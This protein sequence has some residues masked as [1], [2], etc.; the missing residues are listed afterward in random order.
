MTKQQKEAL[1]KLAVAPATRNAKGSPLGVAKFADGTTLNGNLLNALMD[2]G[3]VFGKGSGEYHTR[4]SRISKRSYQVEMNVYAI[5]EAG[6]Q[7]LGEQEPVAEQAPASPWKTFAAVGPY[8]W[9]VGGTQE[10][11]I[12]NARHNWPGFIKERPL[13]KNFS[14]Y[15]TDAG[16]FEI[17]E[18]D[19]AVSITEPG[20]RIET[21]QVSA[22]AKK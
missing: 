21:L 8:C 4:T 18:F 16:E 22:L 13:A 15:A 11:A 1:K 2:A 6:R 19:G 5:T 3:W 7:A 9:G 17:S 14:V 10:I 20:C 12:K